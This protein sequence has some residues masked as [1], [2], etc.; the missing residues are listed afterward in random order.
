MCV[1][2]RPPN[3]DGGNLVTSAGGGKPP[4]PHADPGFAGLPPTVE[5]LLAGTPGG[6]PGAL[7][8]GGPERCE[9]IGLVLLDAFGWR[10]VQRHAGHPLLR[11]LREHG[12]VTRLATQFPSTTTAHVTTMH[13]G[14]PVGDHGL[15]EWNVY[16]PALDEVITPIIYARAGDLVPDT[17]RGSR[18]GI[19]DI[20][21]PGTIYERLAERGVR[22]VV[23][24]PAAFSPS[25]YDS[26]AVRGAELRPYRSFEEA[27]GMLAGALATPGYVYLYWHMIDAIGHERGPDS[28]EFDAACVAALD[29][30]ERALA[31]V[32]GPALMLVTA[33]HGQIAVDPS[34]V[35]YLE[36][37]LPE[38]DDHL[39]RGAS[40]GPLGPAG[41]A[42]DLFLHA[43]PGRAEELAAELRARLDGRAEV[44][45]TAEL[46]ARGLFGVVGPRLRARLADLCV[47]P[48]PGRMAWLRSAAS[49]EQRF[50]GHHGG[51][52][53]EEAETWLGAIM[54]G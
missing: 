37:F 14:R 13:T 35:D 20:V 7:L 39:R 18:A 11:R 36:D 26:V 28:P 30:L 27:A 33:D 50:R 48:A 45:L 44:H 40:G 32:A 34:R 4:G 9:R 49:V 52:T 51:L 8:G 5:R 43:A 15:Y 42:R 54:L 53:P 22:S 17:L 31:T 47:L 23:L 41:S 1:T 38:I 16:E 3:R 24:Q 29:A 19:G 6:L 46:E 10:F 2:P 12:A 21:P 25:T